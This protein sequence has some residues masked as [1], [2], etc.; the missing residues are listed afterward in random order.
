MH[1]Q[2][3]PV[4]LRAPQCLPVP[5]RAP[6]CLA[7]LLSIPKVALETAQSFLKASKDAQVDSWASYHILRAPWDALGFTKGFPV[8]PT[9]VQ[10]CPSKFWVTPDDSS[11]SMGHNRAPWGALRTSGSALW[12]HHM[13]WVYVWMCVMGSQ[14]LVTKPGFSDVEENV[15]FPWLHS[16]WVG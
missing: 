16:M 5:L 9:V 13:P 12:C 1:P 6:Q 15:I 14:Q 8:Y 11:S 4:L 3:P 7:V 10:V 2:H